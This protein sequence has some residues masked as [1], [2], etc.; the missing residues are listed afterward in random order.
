MVLRPNSLAFPASVLVGKDNREE[1]S[2]NR[3]APTEAGHR[4]DHSS[5]FAREPDLVAEV[6]K[7][8]RLG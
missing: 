6:L 8:P 4:G 5:P 7:H 3:R 2:Q 1:I